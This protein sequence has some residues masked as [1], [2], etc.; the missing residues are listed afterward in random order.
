MTRTGKAGFGMA[1][2]ML[3]GLGML[4]GHS[5]GFAA[6]PDAEES[7]GETSFRQRS[8]ARKEKRKTR[9]CIVFDCLDEVR[10]CTASDECTAWMECLETCGDDQMLCPTVCGAF[11]QAP[12]INAFTQCALD[13]GC[14]EID[15]SALPACSMPDVPLEPVGD[16]DGFWWVSAIHGHEYV[17]YDDCQRFVLTQLDATR[18]D[19]WNSTQ[20]SHQGETRVVD[21]MG[22]YTRMPDGTLQLAYDNW[23][24]YLEQYNPVFVSEQV[25][26]MHVCSQDS[27][28]EAHDYGALVLTREP[29]ATLGEAD[30]V[31]LE[32]AVQRIYGVPLADFRQIGTHECSN[33]PASVPVNGGVGEQV[34]QP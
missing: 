8:A 31:Q 7:A 28:D 5:M 13:N 6:T 25:M 10:A 9:R 21:N 2:A 34:D 19:V 32:E 27:T 20:V 26:V 12:E 16:I 29:L 11:Y 17:L 18:I 1:V 24:G 3:A 23:V 14:I 22:G 33:G 30:R 4:V 15:F